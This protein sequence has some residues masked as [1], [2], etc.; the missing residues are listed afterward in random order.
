MAHQSPSI[1]SFFQATK[2]TVDPNSSFKASNSRPGD[3]FTSEEVDAVLHPDI[4]GSWLPNRDY[5]EVQIAEIYPGPR[6]IT[7]QGRIANFYDQSTSSNKPKAAKGCLK[8]IVKD[9]SGAITVMSPSCLS[10]PY[11]HKLEAHFNT[12]STP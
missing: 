1:Q 6:C 4:D 11:L 7:F 8:I 5:E 12:S 2:P 3:G 10:L 9:D